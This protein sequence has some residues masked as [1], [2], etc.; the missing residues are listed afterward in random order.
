MYD[1]LIL[2][3]S[4]A[5]L[6]AALYTA[7]AGYKTALIGKDGGSLSKAEKIENY[8]GTGEI[9]GKELL[10]R[11]KEQAK[12]VGAYLISDEV[13]GAEWGGKSF[14]IKTVKGEYESVSLIIALGNARKKPEIKG[15][16]EYLGRGVSFCAV[17]DGFFFK[18]KDV[19]VLGDGNFALSEAEYL[20]KIV[21]S[22]TVLTNGSNKLS[23]EGIIADEI[24]E[25]TGKETLSKVIFK[26]GKELLLDG[27]FV[28]QGFAGSAELASKLGVYC[29][30][31]EI[32][33]D[34]KMA[35]GLPGCFA[36]GDCTG[37]IAQV[38]IAVGEGAR[39]G[40]SVTEYLKS[41]K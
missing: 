37:G 8:F 10:K 27:L 15:V 25:V 5:G 34:E 29:V 13:T 30:N 14:K 6:S 3:M 9:S 35:T 12:S 36:A 18:N 22:V 4:A 7:R 31:G 39:A 23:G 28:A 11:G 19:A 24:E 21:R 1:V 33:T 40:L 20:K 32:K 17:C 26:N 41:L 2:G 16:S 38:S